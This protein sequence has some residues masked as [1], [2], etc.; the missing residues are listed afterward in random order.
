MKILLADDDRES[1]TQLQRM[2]A[3]WQHDVTATANGREAWRLLQEGE[4]DLIIASWIMPGM[5]GI[6]LARRINADEKSRRPY[7]LLLTLENGGAVEGFGSGVDDFIA[8]PIEIDQVHSRLN[9]AER[10]IGLERNLAAHSKEL[11]QARFT[12]DQTTQKMKDELEAGAK[13][14]RILLPRSLPQVDGLE[15]A[16]TFRPCDELAGDLLNV[17]RLDETRVGFYVLDVSGHGL[18]AALM[19]FSLHELLTPIIEQSSLLKQRSEDPPYYHITDPDVVA[20]RLN[21]N[22]QINEET[23]QY[24]TMIYAIFNKETRVLRYTQAGHPSP[25]LL[26]PDGATVSLE[27]GG[28]PVGIVPDAQYDLYERQLNPGERLYFFSDGAYEATRGD[29]AFGLER[30]CQTIADGQSRTLQGSLQLIVDTIDE[31][32]GSADRAVDDVS[33]LAV[34]I[35]ETDADTPLALESV[36]PL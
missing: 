31:W 14:Q 11:S 13:M 32:L 4:F 16:W 1:R 25:I 36:T 22:F 17:F 30:L 28:L 7:I 12:I 6:E 5:D 2:I 3:A 15:F 10:I 29:D 21:R 27:G 34:E 19:S 18:P 26:T 8:K 20:Q 9:T 23:L 33:L 24:F 35:R